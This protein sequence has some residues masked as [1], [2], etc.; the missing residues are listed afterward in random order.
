MRTFCAAHHIKKG[1]KFHIE[2]V[3]YKGNIDAKFH[4]DFLQAENE[5]PIAT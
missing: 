4:I 2:R 1:A 5:P 3:D